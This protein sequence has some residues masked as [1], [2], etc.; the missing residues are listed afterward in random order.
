MKLMLETNL[1]DFPNVIFS[2][3]HVLTFLKV[4][5]VLRETVRRTF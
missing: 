3:W 5:F 4:N 1:F 2:I